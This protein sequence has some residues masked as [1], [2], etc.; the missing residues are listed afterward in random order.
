VEPKGKTTTEGQVVKFECQTTGNPSPN[1]TWLK[2]GSAVN[3]SVDPRFYSNDTILMITNVSRI[4]SGTYSCNASNELGI[5]SAE[6][7][8]DVRYGPEFVNVPQ[9]KTPNEGWS[10][11]FECHTKGNPPP[12]VTWLKNGSALNTSVDPRFYSNGTHLMITNVNRTDSGAYRCNASSILGPENDGNETSFLMISNLNRT[13]EASYTC[14][15]KNAAG[16]KTSGSVNLAVNYPPKFLQSLKDEE[17]LNE[18]DNL[19]LTCKLEGKPLATVVW[20]K[21]NTELEPDSRLIITQPSSVDSGESTLT[22]INVHRHD[23]AYYKCLA[24]NTVDTTTSTTN[25]SVVVQYPPKFF[26]S[27]KN[28]TVTEKSNVT[29]TCQLECKPKC[30]VTWLKDNTPLDTSPDRITV[31]HPGSYGNTTSSLTITNLVRTDEARY[32]CKAIN[33]AGEK[34]SEQGLLTVNYPPKFLEILKAEE[35]R[36]ETDNLTLTCKLEGKPLATVLWLK[37]NT[38]LEPD[39]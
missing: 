36:N 37:D 27:P 26:Q 4:D 18:T 8:L 17:T 32:S 31:T 21:D 14:R 3:T 7:A 12:T 19:T 5:I 13:D 34:S 11:T 28:E 38:E 22:I 33:A 35:M 6:A 10:V 30:S 24:N 1:V 15:A 20:L 29:L 25:T 39:S 2:S 23:E 9:D 16:E